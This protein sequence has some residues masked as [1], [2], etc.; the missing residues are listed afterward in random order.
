ME[1]RNHHTFSVQLI[2]NSKLVYK[3]LNKYIPDQDYHDDLFQEIALKAWEAYHHFRGDC[4]F[5]SWIGEIAR[6][7]VIDKLRRLK[8]R[9]QNIHKFNMFYEIT[10]SIIDEPYQE[11]E[12]PVID[13]LSEV[14]K[15]TLQMRID[16]LTFAEIS[17]ITGEPTSRLL[18]RMHRI[19]DRLSKSAKSCSY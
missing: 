7:T 9:A 1:T 13:S 5:S 10:S 18:V 15:R 4:K 14:E 11:I 12:F 6:Y 8:V 3:I 17:K 16:G 19:K 2:D